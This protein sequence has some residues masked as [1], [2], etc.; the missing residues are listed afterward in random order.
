VTSA[1]PVISWLAA[2]SAGRGIDFGATGRVNYDRLA[3]ASV[4]VAAGLVD[5]G[6]RPGEVVAVVAATG[7]GFVTAAYGVLLAGAALSA[8]PPPLATTDR[9]AYAAHVGGLLA[10]ARPVAVLVPDHLADRIGLWR[11]GAV[12]ARSVGAVA[13]AGRDARQPPPGAGPLAL[14]QLTSGSTDRPRG[15][16]IGWSALSAN[17]AAITRWLRLRPT[18]AVASWLPL[19]HDMGLVGILCTTVASQLDLRLMTPE[20]FMRTP[21]EYLRQFGAG[22]ATL[23]AMPA[24]GLRHILRR[25]PSMALDGLDFTGWR[26]LVLG[27]ERI[28]PSDLDNFVRLLRPHGFDRRAPMPAYGLAEATV[29]VTGSPLDA[30][31]AVLHV[32]AATFAQGRPV[33]IR[34]AAGP[35]TATLVG[36]GPPLDGVRLALLDDDGSPVPA[37]WVGE[38]VVAGPGIAD[39]YTDDNHLSHT[40]IADG[41]LWTGDL[42]ALVGG[43]LFVLGRMGDSVKVRG[44]ALFA[45]VLEATAVRAGGAPEHIALLLG[46]DRGV[47]TAVLVL[48]RADPG[49]RTAVRDA[50]RPLLGGVSLVTVDAPG[51]TIARTAS[52][53]P[54]RREL[55]RRYLAGELPPGT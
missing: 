51:R 35:G 44:R 9:S 7:P 28:D 17:V 50:L 30:E 10:A 21:L 43:D 18:D 31:P 8:I 14:V 1:P 25:V 48:E 49:T 4:D 24:F 33:T 36:C 29:A 13:R 37:G 42:G 52:G 53:K 19:H 23:T 40:R 5:L 20:T 12:V 39:G 41:R 32:D 34:A 16:S 46:L 3:T 54:R 45:E 26:G 55:W 27:A 6:V 11:H 47:P 15:V 2:P 38:I 22:G